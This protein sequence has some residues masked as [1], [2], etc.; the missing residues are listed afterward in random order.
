MIRPCEA[1][2]LWGVSSFL[3]GFNFNVVVTRLN[4]S[5]ETGITFFIGWFKRWS[6]LDTHAENQLLRLL[7]DF[8]IFLQA[9]EAVLQRKE[10]G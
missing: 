10:T 9:G 6:I 5:K 8:L 1:L 3:P 4:Q 7:H 2:L